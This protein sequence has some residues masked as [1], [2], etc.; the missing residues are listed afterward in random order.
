MPN[1][2]HASLCPFATSTCRDAGN[3][4][5]SRLDIYETF[6][7]RAFQAIFTFCPLPRQTAYRGFTTHDSQ[8]T[9]HDSRPMTQ[10]RRAHRPA[11]LVYLVHQFGDSLRRRKLRN[12]VSEIEHVA[13]I[14]PETFQRGTHFGANLP[15]GRK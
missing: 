12:A 10:Q 11:V 15:G 1:L 13:G 14:W 4:H 2:C 9:I 8:F 3:V 7:R 6:S 5:K